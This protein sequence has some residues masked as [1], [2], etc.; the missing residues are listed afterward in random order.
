MRYLGLVDEQLTRFVYK[1]RLLGFCGHCGSLNVR[2]R[3]YER[4]GPL[5]WSKMPCI[6]TNHY[7]SQ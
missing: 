6:I 1:S 4:T 3:N 2:I 7:T 5:Q